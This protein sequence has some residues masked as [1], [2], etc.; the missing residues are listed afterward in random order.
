MSHAEPAGHFDATPARIE[1]T[2]P[3][4]DPNSIH[5]RSEPGVSQPPAKASAFLMVRETGRY[6]NIDDSGWARIEAAAMTKYL[7]V[8]YYEDHYIVVTSGAWKGYYL[9]YNNDYY[10][11]AYSSWRNASYW[12][13]EPLN[14]SPYPGMYSYTRSGVAYLCCNG[15]ADNIDN[16]IQIFRE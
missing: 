6:I 16:L 13:V 14:C 15:V 11:G 9:S 1:G 3:G 12:A 5:K 10:V 2:L 8:P 7:L 4:E